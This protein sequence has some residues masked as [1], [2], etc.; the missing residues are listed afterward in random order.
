MSGKSYVR[1]ELVAEKP[2]TK[3]WAVVSRSSGER[4]GRVYWYSQWRRYVFLPTAGTLWSAGCLEEVV[5]FVAQK[6][7][8]HKARRERERG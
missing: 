4:L 3:V 1:F 5:G 6:M 8:E 7:A 2:K